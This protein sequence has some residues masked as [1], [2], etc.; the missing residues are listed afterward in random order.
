MHRDLT[1]LHRTARHAKSTNIY[2]YTRF[3]I[4]QPDGRVFNETVGKLS[5]ADCIKLAQ[6]AKDIGTVSALHQVHR[7][8][9]GATAGITVHS[10]GWAEFVA[11]LG[12][13]AKKVRSEQDLPEYVNAFIRAISNAKGEVFFSIIRQWKSRRDTPY[14]CQRL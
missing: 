5:M 6:E 8:N 4:G 10:K 7:A 12:S 2:S 14:L 11:Q 13:T 9:L 3:G 1:A